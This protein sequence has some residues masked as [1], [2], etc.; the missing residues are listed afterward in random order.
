MRKA[1]HREFSSARPSS[2]KGDVAPRQQLKRPLVTFFT[3]PCFHISWWKWQDATCLDLDF[4][5]MDGTA[6]YRHHLRGG[7]VSDHAR[8][9]K[10]LR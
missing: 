8:D 1:P 7:K 3:L 9:A 5:S 10:S 4:F 6:R 2:G